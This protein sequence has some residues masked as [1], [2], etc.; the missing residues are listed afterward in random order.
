MPQPILFIVG[1]HRSGTTEVLRACTNFMG[2]A[3]A[4]EGYVWQS[5][6]ILDEHYSQMLA[7][8]G[9]PDI[10]ATRGFA[11]VTLGRDKLVAEYASHLLRLHVAAFGDKPLVD[12]TPGPEM[13]RACAIIKREL[14]DSQFV[15]MRRRGIENVVSRLRRFPGTDFTS[16][17][18]AWAQAMQAWLDVRN[19]LNNDYI[20]IDQHDLAASPYQTAQELVA[21][22]GRGDASQVAAF[23]GS[24][25]AE[26]TATSFWDYLDYLDIA[27]TGWNDQQRKAFADICGAQMIA[28]GYESTAPMSRRRLE[29]AVDIV[30]AC[31]Q[32][33][34]ILNENKWARID[35]DG[36][37]LHANGPGVGPLEIAIPNVLPRGQYRFEANATIMDTRC[38]PCQLELHVDREP[39][40]SWKV[41][42]DPSIGRETQWVVPNVE[43]AST[44]GVRLRF[45]VAPGAESA[46]F[47]SFRIRGA[48]FVPEAMSN[49]TAP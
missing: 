7:K 48:R 1:A 24:R 49:T 22:I 32:R 45:A 42:V 30:A 17:C 46:A 16:A 38:P 41:D 19:R 31:R 14:P 5:L 4:I 9:G 6:R 43:V 2:Y 25:F 23:F 20:E 47:S 35:A 36:I 39:P 33:R 34:E 10:P 3:G 15:F 27:D 40:G 44:V 28:F 37:W 12:K 29:G 18:R 11:I 8:L 21:F 26:R 13:I